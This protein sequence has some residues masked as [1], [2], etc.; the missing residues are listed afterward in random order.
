MEVGPIKEVEKP[1]SKTMVAMVTL[2]MSSQRAKNGKKSVKTCIVIIFILSTEALSFLSNN[3]LFLLLYSTVLDNRY[4][5]I[6]CFSVSS[7]KFTL[8]N[9]LKIKKNV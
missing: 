7:Y 5:N 9:F 3:R 8:F 4:L 2:M 1:Y 6:F